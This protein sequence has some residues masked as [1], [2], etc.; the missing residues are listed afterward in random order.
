LKALELDNT[1]AGAHSSL[2]II[3][4]W[5]DWDWATSQR[6]LLR[7]MELDP[8]YS[9][10]EYG[11]YLTAMGRLDEAIRE[12]EIA[13]GYS[14]L[15]L[16]IYFDFA[17]LYIYAGRYDQA[18]EKARKGIELDENHWGSYVAL[19][20]AYERK[21][22]FPEAIAAME[23]A[24]SLDINNASITG[25]LGYVYA[26]AGKKAEAQKVLDE[27]KELSKQRWVSPFNIAIVYAGLN[28]KDQ[29]FEWL[30]KSIEARS[31]L[32]L[33]KVEI[34]F[35]NLRSDQRYKEFLKRLNLPE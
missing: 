18:I 4:F 14:L 6:E 28:D 17:L 32:A 7:S 20:L 25:Y 9:H 3:A 19:G 33:A 11:L 34:G 29:A 2:G 27:L 15:D 8:T 16:S 10:K 21:G 1:L 5:Y 30:N 26:K 24:H 35:D 31:L 12:D 23:K 13:Q 22:Q